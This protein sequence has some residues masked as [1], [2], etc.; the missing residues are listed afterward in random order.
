M[1][2]SREIFADTFTVIFCEI[3]PS[4]DAMNLVQ[5]GEV[6]KLEW[7]L[8]AMSLQ[9][10]KYTRCSDAID[11]MVITSRHVGGIRNVNRLT[12]TEFKCGNLK[13]LMPRLFA[14]HLK[15]CIVP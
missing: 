12:G 10:W 7:H 6:L 2:R 11:V 5:Q 14:N 8:V 15:W 9:S 4:L 1:M 13:I 3:V